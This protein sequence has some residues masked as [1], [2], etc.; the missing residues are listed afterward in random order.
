MTRA[1]FSISDNVQDLT[2]N[3]S[4]DEKPLKSIES[5]EIN[6]NFICVSLAPRVIAVAHNHKNT[7]AL[8][9]SSQ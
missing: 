1:H 2:R 6:R 3:S 7:L 9:G 8:W 4:K 5:S